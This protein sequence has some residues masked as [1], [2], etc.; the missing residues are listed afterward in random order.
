MPKQ[1]TSSKGGKKTGRR[2]GAQNTRV[3]IADRAHKKKL[4]HERRVQLLDRVSVLESQIQYLLDEVEKLTWI[5]Y[6]RGKV[7]APEDQNDLSVE[8]SEVQNGD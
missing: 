3:S 1:N 4:D 2:F 5:G 8:S 7:E 6:Q